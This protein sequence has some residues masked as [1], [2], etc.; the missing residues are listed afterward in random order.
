[1]VLALAGDSTMTREVL[2]WGEGV[3]VCV[4][5]VASNGAGGALGLRVPGVSL[6]TRLGWALDGGAARLAMGGASAF[7][8]PAKNQAG[9][10][11]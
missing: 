10:Q 6:V 8:F 5:V 9:L 2:A 4:G 7:R 1:M 11:G 3:S